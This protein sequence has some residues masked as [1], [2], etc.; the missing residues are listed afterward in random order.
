M[1]NKINIMPN[2][3]I[4]TQFNGVPYNIYY[5]NQLQIPPGLEFQKNSENKVDN[6][7]VNQEVKVEENEQ[8]IQK[9]NKKKSKKK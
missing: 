9:K 1:D 3:P 8:N 7:N 5:Q 4:N 2:E 6:T